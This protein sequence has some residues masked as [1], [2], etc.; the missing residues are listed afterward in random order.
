M[1]ATSIDDLLGD[2]HGLAS[3]LETP[4]AFT[5]FSDLSGNIAERRQASLHDLERMVR[6]ARAKSKTALPLFKLA[7]FGERLS[8]KGSLRHAGN[9]EAI[10]GIEGD[11]DAGTLSMDAAADRLASAGIAA[12]LYATPSSTTEEPRWRVLAPLAAS[13]EPAEREALTAR[14]NG[15]LGGA[16]APESFTP[17][18]AYFF[19]GVSSAPATR[20]VEGAEL[21]RLPQLA[22]G[23]IGRDGK[24]YTGRSQK[25]DTAQAE[26]DGGF[27]VQPDWP[28]IKTALTKISA[29]DYD[30][31]LTV[32]MALHHESRGSEDGRDAFDEWSRSSAKYDGRAVREKWE[33]FTRKPGGRTIATVFELAKASRPDEPKP[34]RL[35]ILSPSDCESLPSRGYVVKGLIAPRDLVCIY[36]APGGGKSLIGPHIGYAVAQGRLAFGMRTKPGAVLYV[37]A[38]DAHGMRGRVRALKVRHG[39]TPDFHLVAGVS[40]LLVE[41]SPDL[42]AL[43]EVIQR[44]EPSLIVIDTLAMAF[45]GLEENDAAA[46]GRVVAISRSLTKGGAAVALVHHDTKAGTATPRGHSLFNG[47]LDTAL[48]LIPRDDQGIIRGKLSKNRNGPADQVIAF[49]IATEDFGVD[50]DGDAVTAP[51]VQE[52]S[53]SAL[54][55]SDKLKPTER[56]TL[57]RLKA[58]IEEAGSPR[59]NSDRFREACIADHAISASEKRDDRRRVVTGAIR[60]LSGRGLIVIDGEFVSL[61]WDGFDDGEIL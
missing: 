55:K 13:V 49:R 54:P 28:R 22:S 37:A 23:A 38:E 31:W 25:P 43:R 41:A 21:D 6:E 1:L 9:L 53:A 5:V 30:T 15:V 60:G 51:I 46:M 7:T 18:Q 4:L 10:Y 47:A 48:H 20:L 50:E 26:D 39:D 17:A 34:S 32:G 29:D 40:D 61:P 57:D 2:V 19:G 27:C 35:T 36:G 11:H 42:S 3:A 59:I 16:L 45:P 44:I 8:D 56:A 12:L 14:L 33:S 58:M 24:P 52:V